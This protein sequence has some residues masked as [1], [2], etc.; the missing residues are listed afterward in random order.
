MR[1]LYL[2][3]TGQN[4]GKTTARLG[5]PA[6]IVSEGGVGRPID[7]IVLNASLFA[8]HGVHVAGAIVN[9]VDVKARAGIERV[10]E[11]G[12]APYGIPLLGILPVRPILSNPTL[13]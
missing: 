7:E 6:I 9:K 10:L 13:E 5:A 8:K 3:A 4:R 11:R 12:L 1:Q 2:A